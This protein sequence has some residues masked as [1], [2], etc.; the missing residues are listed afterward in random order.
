MSALN[1]G[2]ATNLQ[3]LCRH[4]KHEYYFL[5]NQVGTTEVKILIDSLVQSDIRIDKQNSEG[6]H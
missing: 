5:G 6:H 2:R 4:C 1:T 3:V